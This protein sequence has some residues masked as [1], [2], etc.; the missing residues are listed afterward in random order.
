MS[1]PHERIVL[2]SVEGVLSRLPRYVVTALQALSSSARVW[3]FVADETPGEVREALA[4][5]A[6]SVVQRPSTESA[7]DYGAMVARITD[8]SG[9]DEVVLTG[10]SWFGP[11]GDLGATIDRMTARGHD[12]WQ[13]VRMG[14]TPPEEFADEGF[15]RPDAPW[16]W[17][18]VRTDVVRSPLWERFWAAD[19]VPPTERERELYERLS[20][21]GRSVGI[22]FDIGDRIHADPSVFVPDALLEAGCPLL[23]RLPF[24]LYPPYLDRFAV[25]GREIVAAAEAAGYPSDFIWDGLVGSVPPK[26][27]NTVGGMLEVLPDSAGQ[28]QSES[29]LRIVVLAHVSDLPGAEDLFGK[30]D[31]LPPGY[32][33]VVT[34]GNG[35]DAARLQRLIEA[36]ESPR[37]RRLE[38]RVTANS[39]G[40]DM[41]DLFVG[42]R[43]IVLGGE[44]DLLLKVHARAA[45]HKTMNALRYFRRYQLENLLET[46]GYV[47]NAIDLFRDEPQLGAVFPPMMHIGYGTMG[48]G[49][50]GLRDQ[51][52][53]LAAKLGITV[54]L[55]R[56]SPL[57][58]YGG[59]WIARPDALR[60][61][62][63][64]TWSHRDYD[65][66][67][68]GERLGRL[69]ERLLP[70]AA[71]QDGYHMRTILTSEH[72]SISYSALEYKA[73]QLLSTTRG[74][75]VEQ[76]QLLHRAGW[77]GYGGVV[78]LTRMYL[79]LNHPRIARRT[80]PLYRVGLRIFPLVATARRGVRASVVRAR[81]VRT[82]SR[83][84]R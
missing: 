65:R 38:V 82:E 44:Y 23:S 25:V 12:S 58:P 14:S 32:D 19:G 10:D 69:Q 24:R 67:G 33:L 72:A 56:V 74:W 83:E 76:I 27:L 39:P 63:S 45:P 46:E 66:R 37:L 71:A 75:P 73:D 54:P 31:N 17:T 77:T 61:L 9:Y 60:R 47:R 1:R 28:K 68:M 30:V 59:M 16:L 42:C 81:R 49:W 20:E 62:A 64:H 80:A 7:A 78:A 53:T 70:L 34:T 21:S 79:R 15:P 48:K 18:S 26:A 57:A 36:R 50:A 35:L 51:A 13:M 40:R 11:A 41:S 8:L 2:Y 6:D 4:S 52:A 3:V 43:D 55:D 22:A 29:A 5:L 84:D